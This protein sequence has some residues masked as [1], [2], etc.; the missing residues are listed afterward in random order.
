V[1]EF[2]AEGVVLQCQPPQVGDGDFD[3]V[4]ELSVCAAEAGEL[5][6]RLVFWRP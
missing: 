4:G 6:G 2:L 1:F 3:L 5:A